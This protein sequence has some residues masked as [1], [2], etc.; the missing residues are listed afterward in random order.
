MIFAGAALR[1]LPVPDGPVQRTLMVLSMLLNGTGGSWLN[2]GTL[3][4]ALRARA[5]E[6]PDFTTAA[7]ILS[8]LLG[9]AD[10]QPPYEFYASVLGADGGERSLLAHLGTEAHEP[11]EE[12]LTLALQFERQHAPSMEGFLHWIEVGETE[13]KRDLEHGHGEVLGGLPLERG[14]GHR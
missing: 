3:W 11:V 10:Y 5:A 2:F 6:R 12:F 7:A 13:V 14:E 8:R 1:C 4:N 9:A